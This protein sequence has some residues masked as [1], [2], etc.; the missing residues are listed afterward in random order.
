MN[1][2]PLP[3]SGAG[4]LP[5]TE[6]Q[7]RSLATALA[8]LERDLQR[9]RDTLDRP[10]RNLRLTHYD[11]PIAADRAP[12]LLTAASDV[13]RHLGQIADELRLPAHVTPVRRSIFS[14]LL[15]DAIHLDDVRPS[16]GL[17]GY[18]EV[19]VQTAA[20]L[21]SEISS[22]REQLGKLIRLLEQEAVGTREDL[23]GTMP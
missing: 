18:G 2:A 13:A 17:S 15:L 10:P 21:E 19:A 22:L 4:S 3:E 5:L 16:G 7:Q 14:A 1:G 6:P 11:D 12:A 23:R 20:Y 8:I 9:L